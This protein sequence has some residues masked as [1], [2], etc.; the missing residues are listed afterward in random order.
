MRGALSLKTLNIEVVGSQDILALPCVP[1]LCHIGTF[2]RLLDF[3]TPPAFFCVQRTSQF[4]QLYPKLFQNLRA[5]RHREGRLQKCDP[6]LSASTTVCIQCIIGSVQL[7]ITGQQI[8]CRTTMS[9]P[10]P[11]DSQPSLPVCEIPHKRQ[12]TYRFVFKQK[13]VRKKKNPEV[14]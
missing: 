9:A 7:N 11:E 10:N 2:S 3:V 4:I 14:A 13:A 5:H 1:L 6:G 12:V 8:L